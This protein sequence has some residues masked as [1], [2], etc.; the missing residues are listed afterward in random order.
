M[1]KYLFSSNNTMGIDLGGGG[2]M[3][4]TVMIFTDLVSENIPYSIVYY[5]G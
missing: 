3:C 1:D 5:A 2:E 4:R